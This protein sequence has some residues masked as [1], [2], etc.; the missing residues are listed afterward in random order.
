MRDRFIKALIS[1]PLLRD[2]FFLVLNFYSKLNHDSDYL[3]EE[4]IQSKSNSDTKQWFIRISAP[5][6]PSSKLWGDL[7]FAKEIQSSL[8]K[9]GIVSQ[10]LFRGDRK[11]LPKNS[12]NLVIRGVYPSQPVNGA[13]NVLW[14]ISHPNQVSRNEIKNFDFVFAASEDWA[15]EI[16]KKTG[17]RVLTLLQATNVDKFCPKDG[18][19]D[20]YRDGIVFVGNSGKRNR[21]V[22]QD[23]LS[24]G[25]SVKIYGSGWHGKVPN[26]MIKGASVENDNIPEVYRKSQIVLNDHWKDMKIHGFISNRIF[27]ALA[28]G[29][30]VITDAVKGLDQTFKFG[31]YTYQSLSELDELITQLM[32]SVE[33]VKMAEIVCLIQKNHSF[34]RRVEILNE[35]VSG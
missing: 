24:L 17:T 10:I 31:A 8:A 3:I 14:V 30:P 20:K 26:S 1:A 25:H 35:I 29:T 12:V 18:E 13:I 27:D 21:R 19:F 23:V 4:S 7:Y 6:N 32:A 28:S 9:L 33:T 15:T 11:P 34:D 2:L 16:S 5:R 22:V